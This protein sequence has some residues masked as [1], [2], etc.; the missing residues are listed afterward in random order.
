MG[1]MPNVD[2]SLGENTPQKRTSKFRMPGLAASPVPKVTALNLNTLN[3]I[4][5]LDV[6]VYLKIDCEYYGSNDG[7]AWRISLRF[8]MRHPKKYDNYA[9]RYMFKGCIMNYQD[10]NSKK[11]LH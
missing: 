5:N 7:H 8:D 2:L 6:P 10:G 1:I 3:P 4:S 9:A 11:T